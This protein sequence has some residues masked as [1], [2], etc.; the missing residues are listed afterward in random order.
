VSRNN[1][2]TVRAAVKSAV[3]SE[4]RPS[5]TTALGA[6]GYARDLQSELFLLAAC[7]L[8]GEKTFHEGTDERVRRFRD[9]VREAS[10][11]DPEWTAGLLA[12]LRGPGNL[13]LAPVV[14]AAEFAWARRDEAGTGRDKG[15]TVFTRQV[16]ASVLQR[17]DEPGEI[18]AYWLA[19]YGRKMPIGLKRGVADAV[20]RLY[21]ER[22]LLKYDTPEAAVRFGD[23]IEL[24]QPRY[25]A[26]AYGTWRDAL[27]RHAIERRHGR[28]NGIPDSLA[29]LRAHAALM[30]VP[31]TERRAAVL[32]DGGPERLAAAGVTHE[33]LAGWLQGPM[34]AAVWQAMVPSMWYMALLKNLANFDRAG[35][36]DEVAGQIAG[37]LTDPAEVA[38]SRQ[39]PFRFLS[40]YRAVPSL[41]W[42][43]PLEKALGLSLANVPALSGRTLVLVDRSPSM[44]DQKFSDKSDMP[45]ADAAAVFG[46]A[47]ALRASAADLVEFWGGSRPVRFTRGD[48]VLKLTERFSFQPSP[49][50]TDIPSAVRQNLRPEH[51]RVV[52]VTD[53]Q[54]QPGYL[55]SNMHGYHN[56]MPPTLIDDLIPRH[57]PL[58]MW[59]F[60]GY[61]RGASPSGSVNRHTLGGLTDAAFRAVPLLEAGR[62]AAWPWQI[63]KEESRTVTQG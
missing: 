22:A 47:I 11:A 53:E 51:T 2:G 5:G 9:L 17:A 31:V 60:G 25:H 8:P 20:Q 55:P 58:Y 28:G 33:A 36:P 61:S 32:A 57:V 21:T 30:T 63:A 29:M 41:R 7:N 43:Y 3:T 15:V 46:A 52:V 45:W 10:A 12:W 18:I 26:K 49:G 56:G 54:T 62:D 34:D 6:P 4:E 40:A 16:V 39:L 37:K 50:G 35:V 14:A 13:R 1:R 59:N 42:A 27:Y 38:G 44:W 23:V 48:S 24:V 19:R